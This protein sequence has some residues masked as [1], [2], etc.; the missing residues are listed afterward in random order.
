M[1]CSLGVAINSTSS[2]AEIRWAQCRYPEL[3]LP[4][5]VPQRPLRLCRDGPKSQRSQPAKSGTGSRLQDRNWWKAKF[6]EQG[7][8]NYSCSATLAPN[9]GNSASEGGK[10]G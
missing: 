9:F 3:Q 1:C 8:G 5:F 4:S 6:A 10:F 7:S 2:L